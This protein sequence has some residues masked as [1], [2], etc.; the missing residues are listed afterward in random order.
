M[1]PPV[2]VSTCKFLSGYILCT[3]LYYTVQF[4]FHTRTRRAQIKIQNVRYFGG[5]DSINQAS[6]KESHVFLVSFYKGFATGSL[7]SHGAKEFR[8]A[9]NLTTEA[10]S[11]QHFCVDQYKSKSQALR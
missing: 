5:P 9:L 4:C 11:K 2:A 10:R 3:T 1:R 7:W 8:V 6:W